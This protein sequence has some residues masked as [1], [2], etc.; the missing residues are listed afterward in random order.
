MISLNCLAA[1]TIRKR[2]QL[3]Q[4]ISALYGNI[5][6]IF[7]TDLSDAGSD[8]LS[9]CSPSCTQ[10]SKHLW[11]LKCNFTIPYLQLHEEW[12]IVRESAKCLKSDG[13]FNQAE[14]TEAE[15]GQALL[16]AA[17]LLPLSKCRFSSP[18]LG[19]ERTTPQ[20]LPVYAGE[21]LLS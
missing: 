9:S 6:H 8:F 2:Q 13:A 18:L 14:L 4:M 17:F 16:H 10:L 19:A 20:G 12:L 5:P 15:A 1:F 7:S 3:S 21:G 11:V